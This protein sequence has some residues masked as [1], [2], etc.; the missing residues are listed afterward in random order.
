MLNRMY[1]KIS[2]KSL[3]WSLF[4]VFQF[5]TIF[6]SSANK[7][8]VNNRHY[9]IDPYSKLILVNQKI[10]FGQVGDSILLD[11]VYRFLPKVDTLKIG[12]EYH[13]ERD[14]TIYS[15][16]FTQIPIIRINSND[17]IVDE[18][19]VNALFDYSDQENTYISN[20]IGIEIRGASSILFPKKSYRIEFWQGSPENTKDI[21][22]PGLRSDDDWNLLAMYNEE[23]K[24]MN[25]FSHDLWLKIH[26]LHYL[27]K[28]PNAIGGV[29]T[30][31]AELFI[32]EKYQGI[33]IITERID[34]KQLKLKNFNNNIRGELYKSIDWTGST[35]FCDTNLFTNPE[36][37]SHGFEYEYPDASEATNWN[38]LG[39][40]VNFIVRSDSSLFLSG[41]SQRLEMD[42][43]V[44]YFIFTNIIRATDN[45]GK[46]L[47][48][49]KYNSDEKYFFL[50][51]DLDAVLG[52]D[53]LGVNQGITNDY[54]VNGLYKKLL[55]D[56]T[57]NG[58]NS[59]LK[60]RWKNLKNRILNPDTLISGL[61]K[62]YNFLSS[63]GVYSRENKLW[64]NY[65]ST[66]SNFNPIKDWIY[67]RSIFMDSLILESENIK[68]YS[69]YEFCIINPIIIKEPIDTIRIDSLKNNIDSSFILIKDSIKIDSVP[70]NPNPIPLEAIEPIKS[71][72][73]FKEPEIISH[74]NLDSTQ[75]KVIFRPNPGV[76][77]LEINIPTSL[78]F[79]EYYVKDLYGRKIKN[80]RVSKND[81][82]I[83]VYGLPKGLYFFKID[84]KIW[85]FKI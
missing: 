2:Y 10:N 43:L 66:S 40:L 46:N 75:I 61:T 9:Q 62:N 76:Q 31:Y 71:D 54:F 23:F 47:F 6:I 15:I 7:I 17:S 25:Q 14:N 81:Q 41:I 4:I 13:I 22:F 63:N 64:K 80:G 60:S 53:H 16:F 50:P 35:T 52:Y 38:N 30:K 48:L 8:I 11:S 85:R 34:R 68:N 39:N 67:K 56:N 57:I 70:I 20:P 32:N 65:S 29:R 21:S 69:I 42:N 83:S 79:I 58:F 19:R 74:N 36:R 77:E 45:M 3:I 55:K 49:G 12:V 44:D 26:K 28:E 78:D 24:F 5:L 82:I 51:W 18:P 37:V 72:S 73:A 1:I 59:K 33:Y 84:G 27:N